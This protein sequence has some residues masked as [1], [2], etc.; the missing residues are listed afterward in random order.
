MGQ[1]EHESEKAKAEEEQ[2]LRS[3]DQRLVGYPFTSGILHQQKA[4][5]KWDQQF[6]QRYMFGIF[7]NTPIFRVVFIV[8]A[9]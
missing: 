3:L 6:S 2:R 7:L 4:I 9:G 5:H 1:E 8:M